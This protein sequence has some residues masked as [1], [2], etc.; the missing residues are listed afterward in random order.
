MARPKQSPIK[1]D[2]IK[3]EKLG[4]QWNETTRYRAV[5]LYSQYGSLRACA[6]AMGIPEH[7]MRQW[8][9][10]AWWKD[11]EDDLK[12]QKNAKT[13]GQIIRL[14]DMSVEIVED[15][16]KNGDYF[17]DQRAG[18]LIRRPVSADTAA[19]I[20]KISLEKHIQLE[21]VRLLEKKV[22]SEEKIG[23]R[24]KKLGEDFKRFA[25]AKEIQHEDL[26]KVQGGEASGGILKEEEGASARVQGML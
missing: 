13:T 1:G 12:A 8:H 3:A 26:Q 20:M 19:S 11:Y 17:F 6:Q 21:E 9:I 23:D 2:V 14:K 7:T 24:L 10:Q 4:N 5:E 15:R 25:K 18:E 22:E 16:L